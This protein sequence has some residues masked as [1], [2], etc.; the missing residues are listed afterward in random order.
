[1]PRANSDGQGNGPQFDAPGHYGALE[2]TD[3][4]LDDYTATFHTRLPKGL[5]G[6]PETVP[7]WHLNLNSAEDTE[8]FWGLFLKKLIEKLK[9]EGVV[10]EGYSA[11]DLKEDEDSTGDPALYVRILIQPGQRPS[12][13]NVREWNKF[14]ASIR[15][16]LIE[17]LQMLKIQRW[18]YV[19]L[20]EAAKEHASSR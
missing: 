13:I 7:L 10:P 19:R 16:R 6:P 9:A 12:D 15:D 5:A 4:N 2:V 1:M 14:A 18:P 3:I 8:K 20:G 11:F 17:M